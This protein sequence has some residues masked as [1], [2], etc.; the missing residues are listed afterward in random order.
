MLAGSNQEK[1]AGLMRYAEPQELTVLAQKA[2]PHVRMAATSE[3]D[4]R[5]GR[6]VSMTDGPPPGT[7]DIPTQSVRQLP[8][9]QA[10]LNDPM[11]PNGEG[12]GGEPQIKVRRGQPGAERADG[13]FDTGDV[14]LR[15]GLAMMKSAGQPGATFASSLGDAG[16]YVLDA[17]QRSMD[18]AADRQQDT[19]DAEREAQ[20][21]DRRMA[22]Y[23]TISG[24]DAS[25]LGLDPAGTYQRSPDGKIS[26]LRDPNDD[27]PSI[28]REYDFASEIGFDN[29]SQFMRAR[30]PG[31]A[32]QGIQHIQTGKDGTIYGINRD[33][34][35]KDLGIRAPDKDT[36]TD[37]QRADIRLK[38]IEAAT[39]TDDYAPGGRRTTI[40]YE[41]A[42]EIYRQATGEMASAGP[43]PVSIPEGLNGSGTDSEPFE[44]QTQEHL[45]WVKANAQKGAY[46]V[47]PDGIIRRL[48]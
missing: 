16:L 46:V 41:L 1:L 36:L 32:S 5:A 4:R 6:P 23:E 18:R 27:R 24:E 29:Y 39:T 37:K 38:A 48:D 30:S 8:G 25:A 11:G 10:M 21:H 7:P 22:S 19:L 14:L 2:P 40:D 28:A 13:S 47:G 43:E 3:I 12:L 17:E 26:V 44:V 42:D 9:Y 45:E 34:T 35:V 15:G 33:G 20:L 31:S